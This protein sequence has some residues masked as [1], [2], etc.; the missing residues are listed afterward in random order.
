[1][2]IDEMHGISLHT[3]VNLMSISLI[4]HVHVDLVFPSNVQ[5]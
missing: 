1:M 5:V 3:K 2:L 4:L